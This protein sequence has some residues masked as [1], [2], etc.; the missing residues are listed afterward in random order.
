MRSAC[1]GFSTRCNSLD[2]VAISAEE[3]HDGGE[4]RRLIVDNKDVLNRSCSR[5]GKHR[6]LMECHRLGERWN[7]KA[8]CGAVPR[9]RLN[10]DSATVAL[11]DAVHH[12]KAQAGAA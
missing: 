2:D 11:H 7:P 3:C 12:G 4:D 10:R 1:K 9:Q 8:D 5:H 6:H